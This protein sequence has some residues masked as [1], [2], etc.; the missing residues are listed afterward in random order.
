MEKLE[1]VVVVEVGGGG[2]LCENIMSE[3]E[4]FGATL[5]KEGNLNCQCADSYLHVN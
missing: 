1:E 3:V 5:R 2:V 4:Q